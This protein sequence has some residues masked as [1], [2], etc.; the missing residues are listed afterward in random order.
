MVLSVKELT[1][2]LGALGDEAKAFETTSA[3]FLRTFAKAEQFRIACGMQILLQHETGLTATQRLAAFYILFDLYRSEPLYLNPFFP[4][5]LEAISSNKPVSV[6]KLFV[7]QLLS[8]PTKDVFKKTPKELI[9]SFDP[10]TTISSNLPADIQNA[11]KLYVDRQSKF[12]SPFK[13]VAI[14]SVVHDP[15]EKED[16]DDDSESKQ[17]STNNN[18]TTDV[19][20]EELNPHGFEPPFIRPAP[21]LYPVAADE[22]IWLNAERDLQDGVLWDTG[23]NKAASGAVQIRRLMAKAFKTPLSSQQQQQLLA[24]LEADPKLIFV[25]GLTPQRLPELVESN[26]IIAIEVLLKL[27]SSS[28]ITEYFSVLVNMQ[29]SLHSMEVVNRLTT[30]VELP[31]EFVHLYISNCISSCDN[32]KDKYMQNRLVR[33]VCVFLQSLIRNKIINVK[34]LLIEVRA[35][36]VEYSK[37]REAAGLFKLLKSL[38][39]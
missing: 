6:E 20:P 14:S 29:M 33:L 4:M 30:A 37:I 10:N 3:A 17:A 25:S 38:E 19:L 18:T 35:F 31:T 28:Q 16:E 26:P 32:V 15:V 36:C 12:S 2:L 8:H 23:L 9:A 11:V 22:L 24:E 7:L 1:S 39:Q 5:F 13:R 27:M 21:P 34:D